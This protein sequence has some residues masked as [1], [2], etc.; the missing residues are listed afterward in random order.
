MP[1]KD[2][3]DTKRRKKSDKRRRNR[4]KYGKYSQRGGR[5]MLANLSTSAKKCG[6]KKKWKYDQWN[7]LIPN[8]FCLVL[9]NGGRCQ[10][11][12]WVM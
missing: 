4:Q 2:P 1:P 11:C 6:G 3:M 12:K 5:T 10:V 9:W 8:I 7:F